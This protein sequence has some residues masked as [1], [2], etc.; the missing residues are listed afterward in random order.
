MFHKN[1]LIYKD[2]ATMCSVQSHSNY[3]SIK[4]PYILLGAWTLG[5]YDKQQCEDFLM[6]WILNLDT[7]QLFIMQI[8]F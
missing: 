1:L 8:N 3:H 5:S 6:S 2:S 7:T 4:K